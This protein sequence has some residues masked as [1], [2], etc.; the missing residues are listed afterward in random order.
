LFFWPQGLDNRW[1]VK[2]SSLKA[3]SHLV[4]VGVYLYNRHIF[5]RYYDDVL[6]EEYREYLAYVKV[7]KQLFESTKKKLKPVDL[8]SLTNQ[9]SS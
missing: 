1:L 8:V 3:A 6:E 2:V 9:E 5:I 7:E 4:R